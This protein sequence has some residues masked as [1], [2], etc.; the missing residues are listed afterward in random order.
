V[1]APIRLR[2]EEIMSDCRGFVGIQIFYALDMQ[3]AASDV[4]GLGRHDSLYFR[5]HIQF[6]FLFLL[7]P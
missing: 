4:S 1:D 2:L 6:L 3:N 7:V 5:P